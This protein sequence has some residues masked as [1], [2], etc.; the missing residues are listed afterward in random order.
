MTI[1]SIKTST[2]A[3]DEAEISL[4]GPGIGE[5]IV[6][7]L[8]G[9][10]WFIIDSC[11]CPTTQR[12]VALVYLESINV[13]VTK[14]VKGILITHWHADHIKGAFKLF[15]SCT[16]AV[17][18]FSPAFTKPEAITF[19]N[20]YTLDALSDTGKEIRELK[21]IFD[22]LIK[23][24]RSWK[25]VCERTCILDNKIH[26]VD[27]KLVALS[28]SSE[29]VSQSMLE[30]TRLTPS[31]K[32]DRLKPITKSSANFNA[33]A[34]YYQLNG[35][36]VLL[37][38]DLENTSDSK[39]G[40]A[41]IIQSQTFSDLGLSKGCI[42]KVPHHGSKTGH[43]DEVWNNLLIDSPISVTTTFLPSSLPRKEDITRISNLSSQFLVTKNSTS[44]IQRDKTVEKQMK[45]M[46]ISRTIL[47]K[48][49]GH[50]Q[51]RIDGNQK[52]NISTN[53]HTVRHK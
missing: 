42:F 40:W 5:C 9:N 35:S 37:G 19:L 11:L 26:N 1:S 22:Y 25:V 48:N 18:Y 15:E 29:A 34:L 24:N 30:L 17:L 43:N 32:S 6:I 49:I 16:Q 14:N 12:P 36:S 23:H 27:R 33:V 28:P 20:A 39:T 45:E 7:H 4:F 51:I 47:S 52:I 2:P 10:E 41:A 3:F 50:I 44:Q 31:G 21:Y 13:D 53:D 46:V 8:G 38:S